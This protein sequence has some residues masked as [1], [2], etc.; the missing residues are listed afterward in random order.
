MIGCAQGSL[1]A[2]KGFAVPVGSAVRRVLGRFEPRAIELYRGMFIDLDC[3]AVTVLSAAPQAKRVLE[4]GCGDG[5]MATAL[6]GVRPDIELVGLDPGVAEPGRMFHGDRAGVS[7]RSITTTELRAEE[8]PLFDLVVLCDVLHHVA[9]AQREPLLGEAAALTAPGG[10]VAV[11][12]WAHRGGVGTMVAYGADR[13]VSGDAT[14]RFMPDAELDGML[15]RAL[16]GWA[17]TCEAWIPP[18]RANRL[19]TSQRPV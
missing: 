1:F 9:E 6:R 8:P 11:K 4:I 7:F 13:W 2:R 16:P 5:A 10:T 12:E 14:V 19:V 3:L 17:V 15:A 18:R